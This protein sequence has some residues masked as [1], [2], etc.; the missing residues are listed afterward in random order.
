LGI[1]KNQET[2]IVALAWGEKDG[3]LKAK[4]ADEDVVLCPS[5]KFHVRALTSEQAAERLHLAHYQNQ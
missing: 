4:L 3:G 5:R 2:A 1:T